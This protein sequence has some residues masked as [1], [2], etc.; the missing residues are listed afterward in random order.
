MIRE[1]TLCEWKP[2]E[3]S[4]QVSPIA[5]TR[6][7]F[8]GKLGGMNRREIRRLVREYG[9]VMVEPVDATVDLVIIGEWEFPIDDYDYLVDPAITEAAASGKLT[10]MTETQLWQELGLVDQELDACRFYTPGML[11]QLLNVPVA[12]IRRWHR[13]GL[14]TPTRQVHKL[15][16]FDYQEVASAR[17]IA[18][19][20]SSGASPRA[21]ESK[22]LKLAELYPD[23][24]RPLSQLSV[25]VEGRSVLM[26]DGGGLIEPGGQK[27]FDFG[28]EQTTRSDEDAQVLSLEQVQDVPI[29]LDEFTQPSEF[30]RYAAELEDNDEIQSACEVYRS[31]MLAFGPSPEACFRLAENLF[32]LNDLTAA[33]ERYYSAVELDQS[34]V[35]ARASLGCVLVELGQYDLAVSAFEG[36]LVHHPEYPDVLY[37]L[38]RLLDEIGQPQKAEMHWIRFLD[39]A[40]KSPWADEARYR[41]GLSD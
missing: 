10:I 8:V 24:Q 16:Y 18:E 34:F 15:A 33:R 23:L 9:G 35:E 14:I 20:I 28:S 1:L 37:H 13:R 25:I 7:G 12:T 22:L 29:E 2:A 11:A 4:V 40:P 30:L 26:R 19:L 21:I 39:L 17:R 27:R 31:L 6:I 36:A 5:N 3:L 38:A 41:L 32:Q